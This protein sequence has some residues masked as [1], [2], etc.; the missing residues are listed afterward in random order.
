M[1][2]RPPPRI[3]L[4]AAVA[5]FTAL[6][7]IAGSAAASAYLPWM[8]GFALYHG[9]APV[10]GRIAGHERDLPAAAARCSNCHDAATGTAASRRLVS[11]LT[12]TSLT[13]AQQRRGGPPTAYTAESFCRFLGDGIDP[14][15]VQAGRTMPRFRLPGD[16]CL[17]LWTY[18]TER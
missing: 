16:D 12:R 2:R 18:V 13:A 3:T 9:Y 1:M 17:A 7:A 15:L 14:A 6:A 11:P 10:S 5:A 8:R 4:V